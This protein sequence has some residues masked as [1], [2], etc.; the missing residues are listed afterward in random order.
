MD[1]EQHRKIHLRLVAQRVG[2]LLL[3]LVVVEGTSLVQALRQPTGEDATVKLAQ[4]LRIP[5]IASVG[6]AARSAGSSGRPR[7]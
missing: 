2:F 5:V 3:V 1:K 7:S 6:I 4:A